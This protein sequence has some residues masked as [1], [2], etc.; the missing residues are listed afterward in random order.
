[1]MIHFKIGAL[2]MKENEYALQR[3][4]GINDA[5][6]IETLSKPFLQS[7]NSQRKCLVTLVCQSIELW[8]LLL[9]LNAYSRC[10]PN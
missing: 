9:I 5:N 8:Q 6:F 4:M 3:V 2:C 1:M 10:T 7:E